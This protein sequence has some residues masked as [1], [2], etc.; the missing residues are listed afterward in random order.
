MIKLLLSIFLNTGIALAAPT[1][2]LGIYFG[3]EA[4][5]ILNTKLA[6]KTKELCYSSD[7]AVMHSGISHTGLW[8][9]EHLFAENLKI[10]I[11]RSNNFHPEQR[12]NPDER[13]EL[14][15]YAGAY[16]FDRGH[17]ANARD[18]H[19]EQGMQESFSLANC[20][21]QASLKNRGVF[22]SIEEA[23]RYLC[24]KKGELYVI[25]G[26]IFTGNKLQRIGGRVLIPTMV[27]KAIYD[28]A[29][30]QGGAYLISNDNSDSY[31][32]QVLSIAELERLSGVRVFPLMDN[33]AKQTPMW[34][35][36][37]RMRQRH[38][39]E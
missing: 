3:N 2:C 5:D 36:E 32:Y 1:Q 38:D 14:Q 24:R 11:E 31:E 7:F 35:P 23:T 34:L 8:S 25:T 26:P 6:A 9:A 16:G 17:L 19:T 10:K 18:M 4:P 27:Y 22:S 30:G 33:T 13:A 37:P 15:D 39:K 20:I 21:P 28:P 12:L 29:S